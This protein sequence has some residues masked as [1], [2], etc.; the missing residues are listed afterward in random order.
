MTPERWQRINEMFQAALALDGGER[1]AFLFAQSAGDDNLR[2]KVAA[3]LASHEK[4]EGFI[5]GSV[6]G[7]G[8]QL[9]LEDEAEAMVTRGMEQLRATY[10]AL[11]SQA[12][13]GA[14][15]M[16]PHRRHGRIDTAV[17][18]APVVAVCLT[19]VP[20]ALVMVK[21]T[22]ALGTGEPLALTPAVLVTAWPRV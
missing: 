10:D 20:L 14:E 17:P 6:F 7:V 19:T 12:P 18:V 15:P 2:R 9:L 8:A 5:Q 3:L 16:H 22:L 1:S 21:V 4:A 11:G 13:N